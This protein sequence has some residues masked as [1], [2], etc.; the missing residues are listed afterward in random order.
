MSYLIFINELGTSYNGENI[1]EFIFSKTK[2]VWG[3]YWDS[4]PC[5]GNP[6][7]PNIDYISSVGTLKNTEIE[8]DLIQKSDF[9]SMTDSID[10]IIA[11]G[12]EKEYQSKKRLVFN[13]GETIESVNDKLYE[14]D[15]V[16][17]NT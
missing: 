6:Q 1:Y 15:I 5:N 7:P 17:I 3:D 2:E 10:G 14:R 4:T 16:L 11:L 9:F 12:W 13:F 8:L